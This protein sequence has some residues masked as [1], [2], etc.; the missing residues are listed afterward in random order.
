MVQAAER[1]AQVLKPG[2]DSRRGAAAAAAG[3][4]PVQPERA[5]RLARGR[6]GVPAVLVAGELLARSALWEPGLKVLSVEVERWTMVG[7]RTAATL[8]GAE[9]WAVRSKWAPA[10]VWARKPESAG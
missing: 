7:L 3:F 5:G 6:E 10:V 8:L 9:C 4:A 1:V 2:P